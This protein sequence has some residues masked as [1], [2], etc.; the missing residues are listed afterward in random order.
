MMNY[1]MKIA[2]DGTRYNGWQ[3]QGNTDNTIQGKIER[4]LCEIT[5]K[6]ID[7]NGAGRTDAG[8]HAMAQTASFSIDEPIDTDDVLMSL[9]RLLP[10]DIAVTSLEP[11][12]PR[13]HARLN[14]KGKIY[15]Y[16]IC[17]SPASP[18]FAKNHVFHHPEPLDI[19]SMHNIAA[20]LCG[21]HDF[22]AFC[23][24]KHM[25]KSTVR[26]VLSIS[27]RNRSD[28]MGNAFL[29]II[30]EGDGFLYHMVR[31]MTGVMIYHGEHSILPVP[32]IF[33]M[34]ALPVYYP[35]APAKGLTLEEVIY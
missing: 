28:Q 5:G 7:I 2:Y 4:C 17:T 14:A 1:I 21:T 33:G 18:V 15:R 16:T 26:T 29:D 22:A 35:L 32:D 25:K 30:F 27:F 19:P 9:C 31:H 13:F 6:N 12:P 20:S 24:N 34:T 10:R 11:A 8:V 23:D 3:R